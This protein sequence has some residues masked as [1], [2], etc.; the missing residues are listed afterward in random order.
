MRV[1][2][3][4]PAGR[5]AGQKSLTRESVAGSQE[6]G[7]GVVLSGGGASGAYEVGVL[8]A[9]FS[10]KSPATGGVPLVPQI[11]AGTSIG[12]FSAAFLVSRLDDYG[13]A[14]AGDL[15]AAW[16]DRL[17][18]SWRFGRPNGAFR[19]RGDPFLFLAPQSYVPNPLQPF[20]DAAKDGAFLFWD[21]LTRVRNLV[22]NREEDLEQRIVDLFNIAS[23]VSTEPFEQTIRE[24]ISFSKI[25]RATTLLRIPATN[26]T[27]GEV[28]VF[29]NNEM[30]DRDGPYKILASSAIPGL[31]PPVPIGAEPHVD[32][33]VLINTPLR[34]V[35][36]HAQVIHVIYLDPDIKKIPLGTLDSTLGAMYRQQTI[37]WAKLV[38]D[39]IADA[40]A[41]NEVLKMAGR[42]GGGRSAP[43]QSRSSLYVGLSQVWNRQQEVEA[44][45]RSPY[46]L[47]T[48]HR[49]HPRED[50]AGG[51]MG[52]LN[53]DR[54]HIEDLIERGFEDAIAHDCNESECVLPDR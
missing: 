16:L 14:V 30:T 12:S 39:D 45:A 17:S 11:C 53:F 13:P 21:G 9:L 34:L 28:T 29:K 44:H 49:Y 1:A 4:G 31:L 51:P 8:K 23:F 26:W 36:G 42:A 33:G 10:G 2:A 32:G 22:V 52:V 40:R 24:T 38:N 19:Y 20:L 25:R 48:I 6:N 37:S 18:Q 47:L 54:A 15:E 5:A 43:D 50:L 41:I 35:T 46:R 3:R 7:L 27:T